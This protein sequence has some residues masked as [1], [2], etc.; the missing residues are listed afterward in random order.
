MWSYHN[1][2]SIHFGAGEFDRVSSL[3]DGRP[4]A[5][6]TY[7]DTYFS[8]LCEKLAAK[9]GTPM[10]TINDVTPN[11]DFNFL[12][13]ACD[14]L[15]VH[16]QLP[17]VIVALGGGSVLDA[18]KVAAV[19]EGGFDAVRQHLETNGSSAT[20]P[21]QAIPIIA[22]PTTHG[23]GSEVTSW[24]TVW[25]TSNAKKFSLA[26]YDLYPTDAVIDPE[27]MREL[28]LDQTISTGLDALSHALESIWNINAN[29]ISANFSVRAATLVLDHLAPLSRNLDD[30]GLRSHLAEASTLAG[31]AFSNT[32]TALAHSLSYPVT[33]HHG[34]PHGIA[35]SFTLADV[36]R[37]AIGVSPDCD[38][39]LRQ[40]FG[41]DLD[42][43]ADRLNQFLSQF[44]VSDDPASF[45]VDPG[46]WRSWVD[47]AIDGARGKNFIG[48]RDRVQKIFMP[49]G[50]RP[51]QK[52]V[53][54][55]EPATTSLGATKMGDIK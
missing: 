29:P 53:E 54:Q 2:V 41:D 12:S 28:P 39:Y 27:L 15:R 32:R 52:P 11:P 9:V 44:G 38:N 25:D 40:V 22:V 34:V 30:I 51:G 42:A 35:C 6:V 10:L 19:G 33:L 3:V 31:M 45:G 4:Y 23:T 37:S 48:P 18:A 47:D 7:G 8:K 17:E 26:R 21:S 55:Q 16:D 24:A 36:M 43:G 46:A 5:I 1:P 14:S 13:D 20:L 50:P 49:L